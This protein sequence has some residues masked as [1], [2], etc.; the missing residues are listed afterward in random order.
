MATSRLAHLW[1]VSGRRSH[2]QSSG[3]LPRLFSTPLLRLQCWP[4]DSTLSRY[5]LMNPPTIS[6]ESDHFFHVSCR[7]QWTSCNSSWGNCRVLKMGWKYPGEEKML[8]RSRCASSSWTYPHFRSIS[9]YFS[10]GVEPC[11]LFLSFFS[12]LELRAT[13][14]NLTIKWQKHQRGPIKCPQAIVQSVL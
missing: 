4:T 8:W 2:V 7:S 3:V 11:G 6:R 14:T 13:K 9:R 5:W 10:T 12:A 1:D